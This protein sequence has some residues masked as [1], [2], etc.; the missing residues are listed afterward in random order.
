MSLFDH[1]SS[2]DFLKDCRYW[3]LIPLWGQFVENTA[4]NSLSFRFLPHLGRHAL[5]NESA[6]ASRT[7][8]GSPASW[9]PRQ[10]YSVERRASVDPAVPTAEPDGYTDHYESWQSICW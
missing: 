3:Q 10:V 5:R 7:G 8:H 4:N 2:S 1:L 9:A 6:L